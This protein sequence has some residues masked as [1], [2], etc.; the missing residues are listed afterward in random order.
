MARNISDG[1]RSVR[2]GTTC[3]VAHAGATPLHT[4]ADVTP[5]TRP[6][7]ARSLVRNGRRAGAGKRTSQESRAYAQEEM[8]PVAPQ[9]TPIHRSVQTCPEQGGDNRSNMTVPV[10]CENSRRSAT[11]MHHKVVPENYHSEYTSRRSKT[12]MNAD[13]ISHEVSFR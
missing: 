8:F 2:T 6:A 1:L 12:N 9:S 3:I 7:R 13:I 11:I 4:D 5:S 10:I